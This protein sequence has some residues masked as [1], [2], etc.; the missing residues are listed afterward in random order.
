[1]NLALPWL[2]HRRAAAA[3]ILPL[4]WELPF[5][6]DAALKRQKKKKVKVSSYIDLFI[7]HNEKPNIVRYLMVTKGIGETG[8][9]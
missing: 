8:S 4:A 2:W 6:A 3:L 9:G 7:K 5:A 1:M